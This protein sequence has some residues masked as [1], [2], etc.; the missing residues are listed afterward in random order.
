MKNQVIQNILEINNVK[1]KIYIQR[2]LEA[3]KSDP[4]LDGQK[5]G[6]NT[7]YFLGLE[8]SRQTKKTIFALKIIT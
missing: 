7:K 2:K 4:E 3:H 6:E 8:K 1:N 5:K